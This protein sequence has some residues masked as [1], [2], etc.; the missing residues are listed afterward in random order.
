MSKIRD[1]LNKIKGHEKIR[2]SVRPSA[3]PSVTISA[4]GPQGKSLSDYNKTKSKRGTQTKG[5]PRR[6][7]KRNSPLGDKHHFVSCSPKSCA[8]STC[9]SIQLLLRILGICSAPALHIQRRNVPPESAP[10]QDWHQFL[11]NSQAA[12]LWR[13]IFMLQRP[14]N[15]GKKL[16]KCFVDLD[17]LFRQVLKVYK[18]FHLIKIINTD[19]YVPTCGI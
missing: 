8:A 3:R 6:V 12:R 2:P 10:R 15:L 19:R 17:R 9:R 1:F 5:T 13:K 18:S 11:H 7:L 14:R 16:V 4:T